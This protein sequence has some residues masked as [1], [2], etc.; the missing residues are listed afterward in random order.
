MGTLVRPPV[1]PRRAGAMPRLQAPRA[2]LLTPV[3]TPGR[4]GATGKHSLCVCWPCQGLGPAL[5]TQTWVGGPAF[6]HHVTL[7]LGHMPDGWGKWG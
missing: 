6:A 5:W 4:T 7:D 1:H 2:V 3:P